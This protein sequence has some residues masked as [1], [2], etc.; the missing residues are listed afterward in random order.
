MTQ[1]RGAPKRYVDVTESFRESRP[2]LLEP[3]D[4]IFASLDRGHQT[5]VIDEQV[6]AVLGRDCLLVRLKP[7]SGFSPE[8]IGAWTETEDFRR[9]VSRYVSGTT[10]PRL[11]Q[12]ALDLAVVPQLT[13][14]QMRDIVELRRDF[15]AALHS[16]EEAVEQLRALRSVEMEVAF[17][18][19][20]Q[21]VEMG[22]HDWDHEV[23]DR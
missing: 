19:T 13:P 15:A 11:T 14:A 21:R 16:A 18:E 8:F 4:L 7:N 3:G 9:Q 5:L 20:T 17:V 1:G 22:P 10:M 12:K 23:K 6:G 2:V